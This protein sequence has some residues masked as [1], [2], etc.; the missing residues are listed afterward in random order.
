MQKEELALFFLKGIGIRTANAILEHFGSAT[1]FFEAGTQKCLD[2][3][4][5]E[6]LVQ[7]LEKRK[8]QALE[9]AE[10]EMQKAMQNGIRIIGR[11]DESYPAALHCCSDAPLVLFCRGELPTRDRKGLAVVGTRKAS[12][13]G[14]N[15]TRLA[16]EGLK[17]C[18]AFIVSGLAI[19][20][21]TQAHQS[22]IETGLPT[23]AV[24]AHGLE[25]VYPEE[26]R[27]LADNILQN[28]GALVSEMPLHTR[29]TAGLFP[30]RNRI[31]AGMAEACL[32]AEA[33]MKGGAM[34]TAYAA[35]SYQRALFAVPGRN[36]SYYYEGCNYLIKTGKARLFQH[37]EDIR[38]EMG[39]KNLRPQTI[40][41]RE[42]LTGRSCEE[43]EI[44][45]RILA[46][47]RSE[48]PAS[49]EYLLQQLDLPLPGLLACLLRME[50]AGLVRSC[51]GNY[52]E[53]A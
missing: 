12:T 4:L 8:E 25:T 35:D 17:A 33:S 38:E 49:A 48:S 34:H 24:L 27:Y 32:I 18:P 41:A 13:Y 6:S 46:L 45:N 26:N 30:R 19:G 3:G 28:G 9:R 36:D 39:W 53:P 37:A 42:P 11:E 16:V 1:K 29:I 47:L 44:E 5:R 40:S 51:P 50:L 7:D 23:I 20:I 21:D 22:S 14:K 31:I 43:K 52:Y 2:A 15:Q 10:I